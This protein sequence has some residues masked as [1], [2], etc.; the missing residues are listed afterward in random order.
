[1]NT[2]KSEWVVKDL[3]IRNG[4]HLV[5]GTDRDQLTEFK[6]LLKDA[7]SRGTPFLGKLVAQSQV[8]ENPIMSEIFL[9]NYDPNMCT[10][11]IINSLAQQLEYLGLDENNKFHVALILSR[12]QDLAQTLNIPIVIFHQIKL[13]LPENLYGSS[14]PLSSIDAIMAVDM[15]GVHVDGRDFSAWSIN[16]SF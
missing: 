5:I 11:W 6:Q 10:V 16:H 13:P 1:M 7:L 8:C 3:I 4:A 14:C 12:I 9:L 2:V 15:N